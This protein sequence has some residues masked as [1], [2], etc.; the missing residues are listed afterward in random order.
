MKAVIIDIDSTIPN[1][2]LKKIEKYHLNMG[3]EVIW[4]NELMAYSANKI[5][6]SCVFTKNRHLAE[7][8]E[9]FDNAL[10]GGTGYS[11]SITLP[12]EIEKVKPKINF[13]FTTRGCIRKCS[14]CFVPEKE[15]MLKRVGDIYDI[16]DGKS[17]E[18]VLMDNNISADKEHFMKILKQCQKENLSVDFN[19]GMDI[20]LTDEEMMKEI[21]KTKLNARF[22]F[23][24]IKLKDIVVD[25]CNLLNKYGIMAHFYILVGF[26]STIEEDIERVNILIENKQRGY[27]MRHK[28]CGS[29]KR[30]VAISRWANSP[31]L[32]KGTIPF[33]EYL[34]DTEDGRNYRRYFKTAQNRVNK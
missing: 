1:L 32:G 26:N 14:F 11:L 25:K 4:N 7:E 29:D 15:G 3:D 31:I 10:I 17:K 13:G 2:A 16:W 18:I 34:N 12:E 24:D 28:N 5:Y 20:R 19:Q 33:E 23:D 6:V 27:I 22:A 8:W 21:K 9:M 30:Y